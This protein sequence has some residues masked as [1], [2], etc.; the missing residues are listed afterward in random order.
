MPLYFLKLL[1]SLYAFVNLEHCSCCIS[2]HHY[3]NDTPVWIILDNQLGGSGDVHHKGKEWRFHDIDLTPHVINDAVQ[4]RF[5]IKSDGGAE[6]G[7]WTLDDV[8]VVGFNGTPVSDV[9]FL[10]GFNT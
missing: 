2:S 3:A 1:H 8:C 6:F 9:I 7:G 4:L 5:E 10:D